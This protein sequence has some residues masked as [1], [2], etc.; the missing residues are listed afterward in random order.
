MC[1]RRE[2]RVL[3][4]VAVDRVVE[5]VG[6]DPAVVEE[7]VAFAGRAVADNVLSPKPVRRPRPQ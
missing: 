6:T 4:R 1:P 2:S 3:V 5:E 7:R